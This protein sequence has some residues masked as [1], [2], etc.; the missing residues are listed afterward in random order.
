MEAA[1]A[2]G[3]T[4][5]Q[6]CVERVGLKVRIPFQHFPVLVPS[7]QRNLFN[8]ESSLEKAARAFVP[9]IMKMKVV[10]DQVSAS[11]TEG[12]AN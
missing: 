12:G 8:R 9:Q 11:S 10:D 3:S 5:R 4:V 6:H 7:H 1:I 2:L